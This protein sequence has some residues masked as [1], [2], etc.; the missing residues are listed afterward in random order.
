MIKLKIGLIVLICT[1]FNSMCLAQGQSVDKIVAVVGDNIIL[2][3]DVEGQYAQFIAQGNIPDEKIKC[4]IIDQSLTQKILYNQAILDSVEVDEAKVDEE[5]E[6]RIRYFISQFGSQDKMEAFLQKSVVEFK[7]DL[8]D[9]I[10]ELLLAQS[11]QQTIT[12]NV[13]V[14]PSDV[15]TYYKSIPQDSL[16]FYN[17]ELEIGQLVLLPKLTLEQKQQ[18]KAKLEELRERVNKGEDFSTMAILYSQDPGS[19]K[20]GGELGFVGRG[21]LVKA[22][23]AVAFKLKPGELS[24]VVET[25]YGFHIIQLIERRGEQVN[26]RHILIKPEYSNEDYLKTKAKLDS[27]HQLILSKSI[28]FAEAVQAYSEDVPSKNNGGMITNPKDGTLRF[29]TD[30]MDPSI[31]MVVDTMQEGEVSAP[32]LYQLQDGKTAFRLIYYKH[33]IAPHKANLVDDYQKM[34]AAALQQ[35]EAEAVAAWFKDKRKQ[36]YVK[37]DKAFADCENLKIWMNTTDN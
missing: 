5:L 11:M 20:A 25:E 31:F 13:K 16:P 23:E 21:D 34:Q 17:S 8:R 19:A 37:I 18:A 36:T 7:D 30:Q 29:P 26:V 4:A 1:L 15:R 22:F 12:K 3:S 10:R 6:R 27:V 2:F 24:S 9:D 28:T 33:R 35:K 14:T 32:Q